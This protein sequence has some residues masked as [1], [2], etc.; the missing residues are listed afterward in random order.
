M[1]LNLAERVFV[2]SPFGDILP[3]RE[4]AYLTL[5]SLGLDAILLEKKWGPLRRDALNGEVASKVRAEVSKCSAVVIIL[6]ERKNMRV[7]GTKFTMVEHEIIAAQEKCIPILTYVTPYSRFFARLK[8]RYLPAEHQD[9]RLIAQC[10]EVAE[11]TDPSDFSSRLRHDFKRRLDKDVLS[12]Q[13]AIISPVPRDYWPTLASHPEALAGCPARFFEELVAELLRTDGWNVEIVAD[14]NM[15]GPDIIACSSRTIDS[16]PV[17]FVVECKKYG[18]STSVGVGEVRKL[19][20]WVNKDYMTTLGMIVTT[21]SFTKTAQSEA[22]KMSGLKLSLVDQRKIIS[23]LRRY[24][25]SKDAN[26]AASD[27]GEKDRRS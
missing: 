13:T 25:L 26:I 17:I 21:S 2:S 15:P 19:V 24:T 4:Q 10:E 18:K 3:Y 22:Q 14:T 7:P 1:K 12:R 9:I 27:D 11:I 6:G 20:H 5:R 16:E 23:W 8:K